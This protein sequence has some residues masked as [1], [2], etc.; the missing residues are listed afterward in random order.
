VVVLVV[1][2]GLVEAGACSAQLAELQHFEVDVLELW[3]RGGDL[4]L[5]A[6]H[7]R[8]ITS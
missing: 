1:R 4:M 2:R 5:E 3:E 7:L 6:I 8:I